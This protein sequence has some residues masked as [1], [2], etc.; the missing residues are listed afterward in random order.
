MQVPVSRKPMLNCRDTG[1]LISLARD[2]RVGVWRKIQIR[3]H[4]AMCDACRKYYK[5]VERIGLKAREDS[6]VDK[7]PEA[8]HKKIEARLKSWNPK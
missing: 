7:M 6:A 5:F 1:T 2:H 4:V 3:M 8:M